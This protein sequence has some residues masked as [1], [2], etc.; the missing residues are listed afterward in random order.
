MPH[1]DKSEW[2]NYNDPADNAHLQHGV[3]QRYRLQGFAQAH[4]VC[5]DT[6]SLLLAVETQQTLI[7][8]AHA[9]DLM[10]MQFLIQLLVYLESIAESLH[11]L[12]FLVQTALARLR[13]HFRLG[14]WQ[15]RSKKHLAAFIHLLGDFPVDGY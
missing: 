7:H 14:F 5:K 8:K 4:K 2:A 3:E 9:L 10:R 1:P 12:L 15:E 6:A 13:Q 11:R